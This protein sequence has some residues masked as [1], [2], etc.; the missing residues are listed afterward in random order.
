MPADT[1]ART[2]DGSPTNPLA[3]R[4]LAALPAEEYAPLRQQLE[5]LD[6]PSGR[7]IY[8]PH[9]TPREVY[10]PLTGC[11]SVVVGLAAFLVTA[12]IGARRGIR[13]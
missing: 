3:N 1:T 2:P 12:A 10:F 13:R 11:A 5:L 7:I 8:E 6:M 4:L 9:A